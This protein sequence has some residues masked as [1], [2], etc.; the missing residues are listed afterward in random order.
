MEREIESNWVM[1]EKFVLATVQDIE[2][3]LVEPATDWKAD[4]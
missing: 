2:D 1:A 4:Y 3:V